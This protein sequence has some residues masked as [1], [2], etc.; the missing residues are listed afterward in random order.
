VWVLFIQKNSKC[1]GIILLSSIQGIISDFLPKLLVIP[2]VL[3]GS[4]RVLMSLMTR[5]LSKKWWE[6]NRTLHNRMMVQLGAVLSFTVVMN[7]P[8]FYFFSWLAAI[9]HSAFLHWDLTHLFTYGTPTFLQI[10]GRLSMSAYPS[11]RIL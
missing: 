6:T 5:R 11:H 1:C 3:W 9:I 10:R 4:V 8:S 2:P 7:A